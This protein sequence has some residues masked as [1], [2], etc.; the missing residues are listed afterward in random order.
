MA[1]KDFYTALVLIVFSAAVVFESWRM[2]LFEDRGGSLLT[3]PGLV[4]GALGIILAVCGLV[5][6]LQSVLQGGLHAQDG[7]EAEGGLWSESTRRLILMLVLSMGYAGGL[8]GLIPFWL[9]TLI[10]IFLSIAIF[11]WR[12]EHSSAKRLRL[13]VVALL[14][15]VLVAVSV[16]LVFERIFLVRLP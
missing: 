16:T 11:E 2:P 12:R 3:A 15:A 6:L 5:L 14:I 1:R 10:F 7:T 8:V 4:P 9:A 13:L